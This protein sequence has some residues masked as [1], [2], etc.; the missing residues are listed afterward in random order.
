MAEL[1]TLARPYARAAFESAAADNSLQQWADA[2]ALLAGIAVQDKVVT[3]IQAP[4]LTVE[5][6]SDAL[7]QLCGD[8]VGRKTGNFVKLL[9]ENHRLGLLPQVHEQFHALKTEREKVVDVE[10]ISAIAVDAAQQEKLAKALAARLE[11]EV[12]ISVSVDSD[13]IGGAVIRAGDMII[14]GSVRGRLSK[15]AEALNS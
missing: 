12:N 7:L 13:L 1:S 11:R 6:K 3:L 14:D 15:L 5:Q 2:L 9:A 4:S 10:L 8:E